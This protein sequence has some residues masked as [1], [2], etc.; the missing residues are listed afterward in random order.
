VPEL[1]LESVV[2]VEHA[3]DA[4]ARGVSNADVGQCT[5]TNTCYEFAFD[6][7]AHRYTE[8]IVPRGRPRQIVPRYRTGRRADS[9]Q[10][11]AR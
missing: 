6:H 3:V 11:M 2:F 8:V 5:S 10:T 7:R 4:E 1:V 9:H